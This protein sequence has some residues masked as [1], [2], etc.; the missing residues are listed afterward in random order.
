M[1]MRVIATVEIKPEYIKDVTDAL[2][3]IIEPSREESGCLQYDL[4][5][6]IDK[7]NTFVFYERWASKEALDQ[8]NKSHHFMHFAS[9]LEGKLIRLDV[10]RLKFVA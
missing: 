6:E 7:P 5:R 1:E 9:R 4:H 8:H 2:L 10:K 3:E